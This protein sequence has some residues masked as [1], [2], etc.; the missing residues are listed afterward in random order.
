M[1]DKGLQQERRGNRRVLHADEKKRKGRNSALELSGQWVKIEFRVYVEY[2]DMSLYVQTRY[3]N[4]GEEE[5]GLEL[6]I[7]SHGACRID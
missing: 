3:R 5:S 1:I 7:S 4:T 6:L 2:G